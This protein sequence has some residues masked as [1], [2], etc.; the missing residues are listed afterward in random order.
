MLVDNLVFDGG[1]KYFYQLGKI[2]FEFEIFY[3]MMRKGVYCYEYIDEVFKFDEIVLFSINNF[4]SCL[5][6]LGIIEEDY[7]YV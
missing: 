4:F 7:Y 2:F 1:F 5:L 3:F 6:E